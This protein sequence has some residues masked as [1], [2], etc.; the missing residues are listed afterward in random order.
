MHQQCGLAVESVLKNSLY[1]QSLDNVTVVMIAFL[2]FKRQVFGISKNSERDDYSTSQP[3][4]V[5]TEGKSVKMSVHLQN[6][7]GQGPNEHPRTVYKS[8]SQ[9]GSGTAFSQKVKQNMTSNDNPL[10]AQNTDLMFKNQDKSKF[11]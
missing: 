1:R 11:G 9:V 7:S 8:M 2:N 10:K 6:E 5:K 3:T 4:P